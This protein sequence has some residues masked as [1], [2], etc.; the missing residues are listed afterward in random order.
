MTCVNPSPGGGPSNAVNF[1]VTPCSYQLSATSATFPSGGATGSFNVTASTGCA[2][3]A[4]TTSGFTS[5]TSG[6]PGV[7]NGTVNYSVAANA[8]LGRTATITFLGN[9]TG[10][11]YNVTQVSA[12]NEIDTAVRT[13]SPGV[14]TLVPLT[15]SLSDNISVDTLL[16]TLTVS[17]MN[18]GPN[19]PPGITT[20]P[21]FSGQPSP[22]SSGSANSISLTYM[23]L[24]P[25]LTGTT[26]LGDL[27]VSI[28]SAASDLQSYIVTLSGVQA[29]F[30]GNSVNLGT[31]AST[32]IVYHT[33][34][35]VGDVAPSAG[36]GA[37]S[38]GD[39]AINTVDLLA[40]LRAVAIA[41]PPA[42][43]DLFGAMDLNGDGLVNTVDLLALLRRVSGL[44]Q[45]TPAVRTSKGTVC[46]TVAPQA[47][48]QP[49]ESRPEGALSF[50]DPQDGRLPVYLHALKDLSLSGLVIGIGCDDC[51]MEYVAPREQ[52][53][54]LADSKGQ[55]ALAWLNGWE[56]RE[57]DRVLLGYVSASDTLRFLRFSGIAN[58]GERPVRLVVTQVR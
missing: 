14:V 15:L 36:I 13:G 10:I 40:E 8:G 2:W 28:P 4:T 22:S 42:C 44:D 9:H 43:S 41:Q 5:V 39:G 24:S 16:V 3:N 53:P 45:T 18:N 23:N 17:P 34:Y 47:K 49:W 48:R 27:Q 35:T 54:S 1:N 29:T 20:P 46:P 50:G 30:N 52:A 37:G 26:H 33:M 25:A 12:L 56:A 31:G 55:L 51:T 19:T 57:G 7:G 6:S 21:A 38:F 32:A 58:D 11:A